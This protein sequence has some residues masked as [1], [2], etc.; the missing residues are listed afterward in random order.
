[1]VPRPGAL[2][3]VIVPLWARTIPS[4]SG[5]PSPRPVK[6]VLKNGSNTREST[7]SFMPWPVSVTD[8]V[9]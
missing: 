8:S 3:M 5:R 2:A 9:A 6:R 4:A 1:M 7:A